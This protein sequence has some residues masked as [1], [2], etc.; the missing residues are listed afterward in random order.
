MDFSDS[1][2]RKKAIVVGSVVAVLGVVAVWQLMSYFNGPP[3]PPTFTAAET[4]AAIIAEEQMKL[5]IEKVE[6][7]ERVEDAGPP[8]RAPKSAP[9]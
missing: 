8:T 1:A 2:V 6:E 7:V 9:R 3:P 5:P 4:Q